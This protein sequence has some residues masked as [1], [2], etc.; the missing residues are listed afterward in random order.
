MYKKVREGVF[1]TNSSSVHSITVR[2]KCGLERQLVDG[3]NILYPEVFYNRDVEV[4]DIDTYGYTEC[5]QW[6]AYTFDEKAAL[7]ML[8]LNYTRICM[9]S[10]DKVKVEMSI[11][12][13]SKQLPYKNIILGRECIDYFSDMGQLDFDFYMLS[14][15]PETTFD[16][17]KEE[18]LDR[19][20]NV[21]KDD[22]K[23]IIVVQSKNKYA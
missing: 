1:E 11:E 17:V 3:H 23:Y 20:L 16:E 12:Y 22:S 21:I 7:L 8:Y 13:V 2:T 18:L 5:R 9:E 6:S 4:N 10:F 19:F 15:S 14:A